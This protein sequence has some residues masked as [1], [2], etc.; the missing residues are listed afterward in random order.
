MY[1]L[2]DAL[3]K[4]V[5]LFE[6]DYVLPSRRASVYFLENFVGARTFA[7]GECK[8]TTVVPLN[9]LLDKNAAH[10]SMAVFR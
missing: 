1:G 3:N 6:R 7:H 2:L 9:S 8:G 4:S 10:V 5:V